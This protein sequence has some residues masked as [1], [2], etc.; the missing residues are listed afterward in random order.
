M[1]NDDPNN[2]QWQ[3]WPE[4]SSIS[5]FSK[6]LILIPATTDGRFNVESSAVENSSQISARTVSMSS[7]WWWIW[8][9]IAWVSWR[10]SVPQALAAANS[11]ETCGCFEKKRNSLETY[12]VFWIWMGDLFLDLIMTWKTIRP[13]GFQSTSNVHSNCTTWQRTSQWIGLRENLQETMDFP[14]FS[15]QIWVFPVNLPLN[16]SIEHPSWSSKLLKMSVLGWSSGQV[17]CT[18]SSVRPP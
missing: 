1:I 16:Q 10:R 18:V 8:S 9:W 17:S 13:S 5:R 14:W 4:L 2:D 6:A 7:P 3:L 15:H 12:A 11:M